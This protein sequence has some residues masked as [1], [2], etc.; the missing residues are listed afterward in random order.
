MPPRRRPA[1]TASPVTPTAARLVALGYVGIVVPAKA[2]VPG[3]APR[4]KPASQTHPTDIGTG[5][6]GT[7]TKAPAKPPAKKAPPPPPTPD[8]DQLTIEEPGA[9]WATGRAALFDAPEGPKAWQILKGI[10]DILT[11]I[12][13]AA[14]E[15]AKPE[16]GL[17]YSD[18]LSAF[19]AAS[20]RIRN[21]GLDNLLLSLDD[22][23]R[24]D[25]G[26]FTLLAGPEAGEEGEWYVTP[27]LEVFLNAPVR[28]YQEM[29]A[30]ALKDQNNRE[31]GFGD[32][33]EAQVDEVMR[34]TWATLYICLLVETWITARHPLSQEAQNERVRMGV[35]LAHEGQKQVTEFLD[36]R[37][38]VAKQAAKNA[39]KRVRGYL[40]AARDHLDDIQYQRHQHPN[41][42]WNPY[43]LA[44]REAR[45]EIEMFFEELSS[46]DDMDI[47]DNARM[48]GDHFKTIA[49]G[50]I[51]E[52]T[53]ETYPLIEQIERISEGTIWIRF[54]EVPEGG[55]DEEAEY[56]EWWEEARHE[57]A[58][59]ARVETKQQGGLFR[60]PRKPSR[61]SR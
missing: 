7:P 57:R 31:E 42:D 22:L 52:W 9:F 28:L 54:P 23:E 48:W 3:K 35:V 50:D 53:L 45:D 51:P 46:V 27:A 26:D 38:E 56:K 1:S 34:R 47:E 55:T 36:K 49:L 12:I 61:T 8:A 25:D 2:P 41:R 14:I 6:R 43:I 13:Q 10:D 59:A 24:V 29:L 30:L 15:G 5:P 16:T 33:L 4:K 19:R 40:K 32:D 60:N 21:I 11:P 37:T 58:E 20:I 18:L 17:R 44:L 39:E